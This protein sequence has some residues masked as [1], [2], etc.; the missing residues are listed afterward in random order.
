MTR[1]GLFS[2]LAGFK[3][4][5]QQVVEAANEFNN[6]YAAWA[7]AWNAMKPGSLDLPEAAAFEPLSELFRALEKKRRTW[8]RG[9]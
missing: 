4:P 5:H 6:R 8:L 9:F 1:R 2:L 3:T 7:H